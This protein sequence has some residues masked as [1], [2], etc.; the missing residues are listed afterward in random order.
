MLVEQG[1]HPALLVRMQTCTTP[2]EINLTV[3]QKIGKHSTSRQRYTPLGIYQK[4][5]SGYHEET[6]LTMLIAALFIIA[7]N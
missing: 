7:R 6:C 3:S 1:E 5:A 4:D 2:L